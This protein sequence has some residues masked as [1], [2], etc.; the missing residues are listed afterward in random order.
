MTIEQIF[1]HLDTMN[2]EI[3]CY[4]HHE[5]Y[6][7]PKNWRVTLRVRNDDEGEVKVD[8]SSVDSSEAIGEAYLKLMKIINKGLSLGLLAPP[9]EAE[10]IESESPSEGREAWEI[11]DDEIPF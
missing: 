3:S 5:S 10:V 9:I 2:T 6:M 8:S 11:Q 1:A 7:K 4:R